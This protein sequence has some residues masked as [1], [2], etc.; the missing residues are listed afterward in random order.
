MTPIIQVYTHIQ[1]LV[2]RRKGSGIPRCP[3]CGEKRLELIKLPGPVGF[4]ASATLTN[5]ES[6]ASGVAQMAGAGQVTALAFG[7]DYNVH[8]QIQSQTQEANLHNVTP[9]QM[10]ATNI[11]VSSLQ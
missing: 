11:P 6:G 4:T 8:V 10:T 2:N 1:R 5:W 7:S 9:W 3:M